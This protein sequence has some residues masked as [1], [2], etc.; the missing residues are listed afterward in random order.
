MRKQLL[1]WASAAL[2][3]SPFALADNQPPAKPGN[4]GQPPQF[5]DFDTNGDGVLTSDEVRGPMKRDFD[6]MDSNGD[7]QVT[8]S[9]LDTF[10]RS[11]KPPQGAPGSHNNSSQSSDND[12]DEHSDFFDN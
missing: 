7:G 12:D 6:Q 8:E 3:C 2:L 10:M 9:E 11:H 1:I 5:S 4:G